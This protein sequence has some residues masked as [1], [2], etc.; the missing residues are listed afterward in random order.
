MTQLITGSTKFLAHIGVPTKN[1]KAPMIYNP[2]F[3]NRAIDVVVLPMACEAED[4]AQFLPL[5][6]K[7]GNCAG[8]LVTMPHKVSVLELLK[9]V[10]TTVKICGSCNAVRRDESGRL[11][12][13]MFDGEG[14]V[15]AVLAHGRKVE[16]S[17]ALVIGIGGAGSAI[18]ASLA[19]ADV[20]RLGLYDADLARASALADRLSAYYP[21]VRVEVG[22]NDPA[23]WAIIANATPLG[24]NDGDPPP[25]DV[26]RIAPETFVCEV[27]MKVGGT[28]FLDAARARGCATQVGTDMLF[29]Q[30][31]AYLEFFG[32]PTAPAEE[33]RRLARLPG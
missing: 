28:A 14:F 8:A 6:M 20:A 32:L 18:A 12:G 10:S 17:S 25:V 19:G 22:S 31:P 21:K 9:E 27:V 29:A 3:E 16:G 2:Y 13:D 33:L 24:M 7:I 5:V 23:G 15:R 4:F 26:D 11:V 1:F 30:I